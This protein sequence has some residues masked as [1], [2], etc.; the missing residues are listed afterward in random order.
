[1]QTNCTYIPYR[2]TGYFSKLVL[3]YLDEKEELK[4]FYQHP[5][6]IDGIKAAI[7][8][9]QQTINH[10]DLLVDELR[11]QYDGFDLTGLQKNNLRNLKSENT[12]TITTAHQPNI[13][14]GHLYFIYK[15]L[16]AI[17]LSQTLSQQLPEYNFVP[18]FYM[19][20]EDADLAEL[21]HINLNG[22]KLEWKTNQ[23]GAVGRMKVD[24]NFLELIERIAS[25]ISVL[26][27]GKELIETFKSSYTLGLSI[28]QAT[29][30]L[31]NELFK[32]YGLLVLIPDN[33][34]LKRP[35]NPI[36]KRE[37]SEQFSKPLVE[38]TVE[39]LG[40]NYK[41]QAA[42]REINLFYL[43]DNLRE[44]I[45]LVKG[46]FQAASFEW[47]L[48]EVLKEVEEYPERF[49]TN[50]ILRGVFEETILPNIA[51]I[52]GAG[53]IAYWFELKKVFEACKVPF[54][55]L[56]LRN[57]FL[58]IDEK[59]KALIDKLGFT[60]QDLF[61]SNHD[62]LNKIVAEKSLLQLNLDDEKLRLEKFY[63]Q[64]QSIAVDVD[65]S[66]ADHVKSLQLSALK[67]ISALEK[68]IL[69]S[70]KRKF[71]AQQR[72]ISRIK[73]QLFPNNSLQERIDNFSPYYSRYGKNW[74]ELLCSK[75]LSL[76][77][78]FEI[79]EI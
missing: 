1:M 9:R 2:E 6:S 32:D 50:V 79:L 30:R 24:K 40:K 42:G 33:A 68:K 7:K 62:L 59:Q 15:I 44:R 57:S 58:L 41:I 20:S 74:L 65:A 51:F 16:H 12:F 47:T 39:A 60:I 77:Q 3:D 43:T 17:K 71:E 27:F 53:E 55:V 29:L 18:I 38:E 19:G 26:P 78:Q 73:D 46:N 54:P 76:E 37:L 64:I 21:G 56:I 31:V 48:D 45:V 75:S 22:E 10:R 4:P 69:R 63:D 28:Q 72:Q 13:F 61:L 66:L 8:E 14:T 35:F 67:K 49:S 23:S 70:E 52:G 25:E 5:V 36:V 11:K 34:N